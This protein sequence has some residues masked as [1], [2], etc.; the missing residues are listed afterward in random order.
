MSL[1]VGLFSLLAAFLILDLALGQA[2]RI[3][4]YAYEMPGPQMIGQVRESSKSAATPSA[5]NGMLAIKR[6]A[7]I[8]TL[9][10]SAAG[11]QHASRA[12]VMSGSASRYWLRLLV[13]HPPNVD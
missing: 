1:L 12:A 6:P 11:V 4:G 8:R 10:V 5:L 7:P 9:L 2:K 3:A 13:M